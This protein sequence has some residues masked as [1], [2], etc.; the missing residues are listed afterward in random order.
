[1]WFDARLSPFVPPR[2]HHQN[3]EYNEP[4]NQQQYYAGLIVPDLTKTG[5][6]S[7]ILHSV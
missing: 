4:D 7:I 3:D 1:V 5:A 6:K 2:V